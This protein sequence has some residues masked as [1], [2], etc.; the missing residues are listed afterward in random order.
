[1]KWAVMQGG[2]KLNVL[3]LGGAAACSVC[4]TIGIA[5]VPIVEQTGSP[6]STQE[7]LKCGWCR[8]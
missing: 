4:S 8:S 6:M 7:L 1:M 2:Q 3:A 5:I